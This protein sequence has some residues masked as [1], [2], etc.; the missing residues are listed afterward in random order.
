MQIYQS[1]NRF[2]NIF[3]TYHGKR[4]A[5]RNPLEDQ[6]SQKRQMK[7]REQNSKT[8][9]TSYRHKVRAKSARIYKSQK[10]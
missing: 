1:S 2:H 5:V 8:L 7:S 10:I 9:Y 3:K 6:I 4:I